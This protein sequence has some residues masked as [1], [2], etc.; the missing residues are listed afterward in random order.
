MSF[1]EKMPDGTVRVTGGSALDA[2]PVGSLFFSTD[3][4]NPSNF[5][6]GTW[7]AFAQGR[8]IIGQLGSDVD[9]ANAGNTGGQK[10]VT[11]TVSQ[12][13]P[14][15]HSINHDHSNATTNTAG[16]HQHVNQRGA[17]VGTSPNTTAQGN[18]TEPTAGDQTSDAAGAHE[19]TVNIPSYSGTSGSRGGGAAHTNMMP[20]I[21][22]YIFRRT[23]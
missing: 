20:Y 21:V 6:G 10:D 16:N 23:A 5:F 3:G 13:P 9:F 15:D 11:L 8:T 14:H 19:H 22:T 2:Y 18:T 7:E 1:R 17:A 4:T 12:L